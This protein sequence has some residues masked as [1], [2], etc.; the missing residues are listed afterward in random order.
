MR[1]SKNLV[2]QNRVIHENNF[3]N[4]SATDLSRPE[5]FNHFM[6]EVMIEPLANETNR[7]SV[8]KMRHSINVTA[9]EMRQY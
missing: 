8:E 2:P 3:S 7:Y 6:S 4:H 1:W 5:Y 9:M